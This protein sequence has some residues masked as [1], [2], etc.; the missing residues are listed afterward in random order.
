M[1]ENNTPDRANDFD[2]IPTFETT[3]DYYAKLGKTAP[4]QISPDPVPLNEEPVQVTPASPQESFISHNEPLASDAPTYADQDF[5]QPAP[6]DHA[7]TTAFS[8]PT[9]GYQE[10]IVAQPA[11]TIEPQVAA[12]PVQQQVEVVET[13]QVKRGTID[14]GL[15]LIRVIFALYLI[16]DS[17][18]I[19]FNMGSTGGLNQLETDFADYAFPQLLAV[20]IPAVE[21]TAGV[22]LLFGLLTPVMAALATIATSFMALHHIY[23]ADG[24]N[25]LNLPESV[26][27][28]IVLTV[29]AL[30]LQFTGPGVISFDVSRSWARRPLASSWIFAIL[31]IAGAVAL[32]WFGAAVNPLA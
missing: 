11:Q 28:S 32:W 9:T 5:A 19:F 31:A 1:S 15:L 23:V 10:P 13:E 24:L 21:L 30:S 25:L 6:T 20:G 7:A 17:V 18:T 29:V 3:D 4:Q 14:F 2:D 22:F 8:A 26:W 27:L 12:V 16:L